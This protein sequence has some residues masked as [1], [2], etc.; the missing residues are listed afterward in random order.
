MFV[1]FFLDFVE[2]FLEYFCVGTFSVPGNLS[3]ELTV[4]MVLRFRLDD[5]F[6]SH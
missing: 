6:R 2:R 3:N 5:A 4:Q 1:L